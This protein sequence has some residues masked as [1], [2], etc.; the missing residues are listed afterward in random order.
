MLKS[1]LQKH[2]AHY[3][4]WPKAE[5]GSHADFGKLFLQYLAWMFGAHGVHSVSSYFLRL[6]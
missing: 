5:M 1:L 6:S 2:P 3:P 4:K